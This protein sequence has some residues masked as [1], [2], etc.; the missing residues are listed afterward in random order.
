MHS[1]NIHSYYMN[2]R[3]WIQL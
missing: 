3:S 1:S 2:L